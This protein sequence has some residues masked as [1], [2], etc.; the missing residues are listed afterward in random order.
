MDIVPFAIETF[1]ALGVSATELLYQLA[2]RAVDPIGFYEYA[3]RRVIIALHR[4]NCI[5]IA[6]LRQCTLPYQ[7][8]NNG[9]S[10]SHLIANAFYN[11]SASS[12]SSSSSSSNLN[13]SLSHSHSAASAFLHLLPPPPPPASSSSSISLSSSLNLVRSM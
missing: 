9:Q 3:R 11:S 7:S 12:L 1:G 13:N 6:N 10:S 8:F 2:E 5:A 4:G